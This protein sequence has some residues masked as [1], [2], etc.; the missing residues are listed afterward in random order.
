MSKHIAHESVTEGVLQ[1]RTKNMIT[2]SVE[3]TAW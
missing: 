1:Q 2:V 3:W